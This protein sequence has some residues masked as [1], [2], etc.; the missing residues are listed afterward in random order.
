[1]DKTWHGT[2][3]RKN[4]NGEN[5]RFCIYSNAVYWGVFPNNND[6]ENVFGQTELGGPLLIELCE[7][8]NYDQLVQ[9]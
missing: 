7:G 2:Y 4:T 1:M 9:S 8:L 3:N 6:M 5:P